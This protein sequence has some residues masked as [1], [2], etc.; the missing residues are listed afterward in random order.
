MDDPRLD[1]GRLLTAK[2][3]QFSERPFVTFVGPGAP[4]GETLT[5]A[6]FNAEAC[7]IAHGFQDLGVGVGDY[8]CLML[9]NSIA[10]LAA[11]YA[12]KKI[13]AVEV[14]INPSFRGPALAR[15]LALTG[16]HVLVTHAGALDAVAAVIAEAP[17]LATVVM[18]DDAE[19]GRARFPQ[20]RV[21]TFDSVRSDD[22]S[23]LAA[24]IRDT[25]VQAILFTSGT[26]GVSKGC[27]ESH[28]YGVD[29]ALGC[30]DGFALTADDVSY[31][32]Y[33]LFHIGAAYYD[34]LPMLMVGGRVVLRD[35]FSLSAFWPEVAG[36]GVTWF[37][38]LGSVQQLL[39]TA[40]PCAEERAHRVRTCWGTP[41]PIPKA[42]FEARFGVHL[43]PGGGY[44]STDTG[45]VVNPQPDNLGGVVRDGWRIAVVDAH[46]E[47][48]PPGA[49]GELVVRAEKP[50]IMSYGYFAMPEK[51]VETRR[52]LWFHTGDRAMI[53]A[54]GLFHFKGR[55]SERIRV[56]GEMVSAYEVEEAAAAHADVAECAVI[57]VPD[58][59]G[60][61]ELT[62]FVVARAGAATDAEALRAHC[63]AALPGFMVPAH[64]RFI[65]DM[66]RTPTGK[67]ATQ[68]LRALTAEAA[69]P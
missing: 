1:L 46:D 20:H 53:D 36:F 27:M 30:I 31:A 4:S 23:D 29:T 6:A 7:R 24:D 33:P 43:Y 47:P 59:R 21:L 45:W 61:E 3:A 5:Y 69:A 48:L 17:G 44:G 63:A 16:A 49:V 15:M 51:T 10:Y 54:D 68:A 28:R 34:I 38:M 56:K 50:G 26:T 55:M 41:L 39:W 18:L 14:S 25:D 52:N 67:P 65:D 64:V 8:V 40:P 9:P 35:G 60:E 32:P 11:T 66:P 19:A 22:A 12:L 57:G 13:G 37:M 62:L 58:G 42:D 2:A